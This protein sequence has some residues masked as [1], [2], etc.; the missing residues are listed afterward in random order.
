MSRLT[1]GEEQ[2]LDEQ[3]GRVR[4]A[5]E[6]YATCPEWRLLRRDALR[7]DVRHEQGV[8]SILLQDV[9]NVAAGRSSGNAE[10][11]LLRSLEFFRGYDEERTDGRGPSPIIADLEAELERR[12]IDHAPKSRMLSCP[13]PS[14]DVM[15]PADDGHAQKAHLDEHHPH[16]VVKRLR[17]AGMH[18]EAD[19]FETAHLNKGASS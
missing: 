7:E 1:P 17:D 4:N 10:S 9:S 13:E 6:A 18:Q 15:L 12:G 5:M 16:I 2:M 11:L 19:E 14:C 3:R 8:L